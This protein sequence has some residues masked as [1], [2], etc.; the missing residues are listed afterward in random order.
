M[1]LQYPREKTLFTIL[2]VLAGLFWLGVTVATFGLVWLYV[3]LFF[4]FYLF[5]QS[6]FIAMLRGNA[7]EVTP[8]QFPDLHARHVRAC[9][10]L[11]IADRPTLYLLNSDG[12]LNAL[13]TRFLGSDYV[14]LYSSIVDALQDDPDAIDF[15]IGHE[16]GHVRLKHLTRGWLL[17]PVSWLPLVG[18]AYRRAQEYSCD[19][20]GSACCDNEQSAVNAV[21]VLA[22]GHT[23]WKTLARNQWLHQVRATGGFWMSFHELTNDYPW[24]TKRMAHM[25]RVRGSQSVDVP[26]RNPFAY[27]FAFFVPRFGVAGGGGGLVSLMIVV[28]IIGILAAVAIPAY[29]DYIK[30]AEAAKEQ[31]ALEEMMRQYGGD[32]LPEEGAAQGEDGA[33]GEE[34]ADEAAP[35]AD[36]PDMSSGNW[37]DVHAQLVAAG[38]DEDA[39]ESA[40]QQ[41]FMLHVMPAMQDGEDI[42]KAY[43]E[44]AVQHPLPAEAP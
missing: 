36:M 11:G 10:K 24:L 35:A 13:A 37:D 23:R 44:F 33:T 27:V 41:F 6:G 12:I 40:R 28:A 7:V 32:A 16:L 39:Q 22:A 4:L 29:Q 26:S 5:A 17:M 34:P 9:E 3:G 43:V 8:D 2:A 1:T 25:L 38:A 18:A 15:Y 20:H 42:N 19:L 21:S 14:V 30:A 31:A